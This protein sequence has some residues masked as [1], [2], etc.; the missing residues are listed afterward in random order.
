MVSNNFAHIKKKK[1][2]SRRYFS[3]ELW[4]CFFSID[5]GYRNQG[6][7]LVLFNDIEIELFNRDK[8]T[9][10]NFESTEK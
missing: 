10:S 5:F 6:P 4:T 7:W 2:K 1:K 9:C 8:I 3:K